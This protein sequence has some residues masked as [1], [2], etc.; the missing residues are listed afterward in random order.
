V[1]LFNT[2]IFASLLIL[3]G[4][5]YLFASDPKIE[6]SLTDLPGKWFK[7]TTG[8]VGG[9]QSLA[10]GQPGVEVVFSGRSH[11]VHIMTSLI[12]PTGAVNMPFDTDTTKGSRS[13]DLIT[14]GLYVF[15]CKIHPYMLGAVIVDNPN[16]KGLDLGEKV[17]IIPGIHVPT[18]SDLATRL[19]R[20]S[21][22]LQILQTG[23]TSVQP[24]P[25][26]SLI[27]MWMSV[28]LVEQ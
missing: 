14:P 3:C 5:I 18:S 23:R 28:L 10:I 21:L 26:M 6:F 17:S 15:V 19:L 4:S 7:S 1:K 16:T 11:T 20:V 25:G 24:L 12:F 13:V 2:S 8:P 27:R 9:S 22:L